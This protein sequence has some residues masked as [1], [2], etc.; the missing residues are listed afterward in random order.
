MQTKRRGHL[1]PPTGNKLP[2]LITLGGR[3]RGWSYRRNHKRQVDAR[4]RSDSTAELP[5]VAASSK[6]LRLTKEGDGVLCSLFL[7][8]G[9]IN[10]FF[11]K[12]IWPQWVF[13]AARGL[14]LV[15]ASGGYF[16][17]GWR[18]L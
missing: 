16:L 15:A 1:V 5:R 13:V 10:L 9:C 11:K 3:I 14:S 6:L 8:Y 12:F 17:V 18:G 2:G 7:Y 4:V